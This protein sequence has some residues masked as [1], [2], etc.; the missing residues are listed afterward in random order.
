MALWSVYIV[1]C[2]DGSLYT[3]IAT[4]VHRRI[5]EHA[6]RG[7]RGAKYLRG[8]GPLHLEFARV[9]GSRG[10]ALR[11]E[12][13]IKSLSKGRKEALVGGRAK[14]VPPG[15][16]GLSAVTPPSPRVSPRPAER[17]PTSRRAET[18]SRAGSLKRSLRA[19]RSPRP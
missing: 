3:G 4:D 5:A 6:R 17:A 12:R 16:A 10:M 19:N 7:A 18:R 1:R 2:G 14:A 8:R 11:I 9:I 15:L 13:T